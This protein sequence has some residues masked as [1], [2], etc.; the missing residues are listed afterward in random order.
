MLE[1]K[2][3]EAIDQVADSIGVDKQVTSHIKEAL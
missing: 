1:S 2:A 3:Q